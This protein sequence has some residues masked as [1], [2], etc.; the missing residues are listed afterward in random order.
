M[1]EKLS[2]MLDERNMTMY[3]LAKLSG[4][5]KSHFTDLKRGKIKNLSWPNM[6]KISDA[7]GVSLDEFK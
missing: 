3:Q 6:K 2:K 5:N 7:L 4:V 1:W